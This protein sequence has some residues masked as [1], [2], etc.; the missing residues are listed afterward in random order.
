MIRF[1]FLINNRLQKY[2]PRKGQS[3][4]YRMYYKKLKG[5]TSQSLVIPIDMDFNLL[6]KQEANQNTEIVVECMNTD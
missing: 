4:V 3:L 5:S 2:L 1:A 6:A